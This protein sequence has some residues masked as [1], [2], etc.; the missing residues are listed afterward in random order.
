MK[1]TTK[2]ALAVG[3]ALSLGLGVAAVNA[4]PDGWGGGYGAGPGYGMGY[5]MHGYGMHGYGPGQGPQGMGPGMHGYGMGP[6][7]TFDAGSAEERLAGLKTELGIT[8]EQETAWQAFVKSAKQRDESRQAWFA[9]MREARAAGSLPER[10]A[11]RDEMFKQHQ[12]ERQ[13]TTSAL[14]DLY[15]ALTP[16]QKAIADQRFGGFGPG[17]GAGYGRGPGGR[18]R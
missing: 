12:A 18:S 2:I 5:G 4:H 10:L 6:Q 13:A 7:G 16:E 1:R 11:Q 3:T 17:Y 15:A 14:K 9:K 8:A